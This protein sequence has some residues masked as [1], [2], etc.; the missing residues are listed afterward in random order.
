MSY[1]D[2]LQRASFRGIKFH[3]EAAERKVGFNYKMH[4]FPG[5]KRKAY[6][7]ELSQEPEILPVEAFLIGPDA[8]YTRDLL[9]AACKKRDPGKLYHPQIGFINAKCKS[10]RIKETLNKVG[11]IQVSMEFVEVEVEDKSMMPGLDV[12]DILQKVDDAL[13]EA[14]LALTET[15]SVLDMPAYTMARA[16]QMLNKISNIVTSDNGFGRIASVGK[17]I[18]D[19]IDSLKN[20]GKRLLNSPGQLA[21]NVTSALEYM[22]D[23]NHPSENAFR[24]DI[25][26]IKADM[27]VAQKSELQAS[28]AIAS[29][30]I[31]VYALLSMKHLLEKMEQNSEPKISYLIYQLAINKFVSDSQILADIELANEIKVIHSLL[32]QKLSKLQTSDEPVPSKVP[33]LVRAYDFYEDISREGEVANYG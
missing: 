10:F 25:R 20:E 7:E 26:P 24:A 27:P 3:V 22:F 31:S 4:V 6:P 15:L 16:A 13:N 18:K 1:K 14:A 29:Y 2:L 8:S 28:N 12:L 21:R 32:V 17:D 30:T 19:A 9:I 11:K 33:S 5:T 23:V